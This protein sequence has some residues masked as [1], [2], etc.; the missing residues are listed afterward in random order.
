MG[1]STPLPYKPLQAGSTHMDW[2]YWKTSIRITVEIEVSAAEVCRC[3]KPGV[4]NIDGVVRDL[5][6]FGSSLGLVGKFLPN[7]GPAVKIAGCDIFRSSQHWC[8]V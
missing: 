8:D 6:N 7:L 2:V 4:S 3:R 1:Q 5:W